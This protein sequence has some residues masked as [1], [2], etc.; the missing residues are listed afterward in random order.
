M[1]PEPIPALPP[2]RTRRD[3]LFRLPT[4]ERLRAIASLLGS[5]RFFQ[6]C[7]REHL[8]YL[9]ATSWPVAFEAGQKVCVEG[10][11]ATACYVID[12]GHA[13]VTIG[14]QGVG[15][16]AAHDIVGERGI[17]LDAARAATVIADDR[18]VACAIPRERLEAV[19]ADSLS[20]RRWMLD[21]I[22]RHYPAVPAGPTTSAP[23]DALHSRKSSTMR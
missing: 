9:A 19:I 15:E 5:N 10:S 17:L 20:L 21:E 16:V 13:S 11:F 4:P 22:G 8:D 2:G 12:E 7:S 3:R 23:R 6:G 1:Q 14:E 18:V